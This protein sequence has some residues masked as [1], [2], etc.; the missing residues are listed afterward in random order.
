MNFDG[1]LAVSATVEVSLLLPATV[2][3][4]AWEK[5]PANSK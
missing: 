5:L 2:L 1:G 4:I 3:G